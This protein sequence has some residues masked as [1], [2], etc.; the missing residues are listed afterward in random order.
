MGQF[1]FQQYIIVDFS[2]DRNK[3]VSQSWSN[4]TI[5]SIV[6]KSAEARSVEPIIGL[7]TFETKGTFTNGTTREKE[8]KRRKK[9]NKYKSCRVLSTIR[10][11]EHWAKRCSLPLSSRPL[12]TDIADLGGPPTTL[13]D[14]L[15]RDDTLCL[16]RCLIL[17]RLFW[18]VS[19]HPTQRRLKSVLT[20]ADW[21][22]SR[23]D[24][25]P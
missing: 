20:G 14:R 4:Y 21:T 18:T 2:F 10:H 1:T 11:G 13:T 23:P 12:D 24:A 15:D 22:A 8:T 16:R 7:A 9:H 19:G 5:V 17:S 3:K 6:R 25:G